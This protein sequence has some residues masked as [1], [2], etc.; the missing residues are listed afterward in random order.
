MKSTYIL[1]LV[2]IC[3]LGATQ[4]DAADG[5]LMTD[6]EYKSLLGEVDSK[7]PVWEAALKK[8]DPAK[9]T[10]SYSVGEEIVKYRDVGLMEIGY[11]R[12]FAAKQHVKRSVSGELALERFLRGIHDSLDSMIVT[13]ISAGVSISSALDAFTPQIRDLE[14]SLAN[15][16]TARIELLEKGTCP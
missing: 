11:A 1:T 3:G 10:V 7:L 6:A 8:I 14:M 9:S 5:R 15:D 4:A 2:L 16:V 13:D 12:Q